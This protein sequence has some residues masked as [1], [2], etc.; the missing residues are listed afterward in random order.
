MIQ[1]QNCGAW[2]NV[3]DKFCATCGVRKTGVY[4]ESQGQVSRYQPPPKPREKSKLPIILSVVGAGVLVIVVVL[5][6]VLPGT[7]NDSGQSV[8]TSSV[9]G[10]RQ[11][12]SPDISLSEEPSESTSPTLSSEPS[13]SPSPAQSSDPSESPSPVQNS[14]PSESPSPT[15]SSEPPPSPSPAQN[16]EPPPSPS[17][18]QNSAPPTS[19]SPTQSSAPPTSPSPTQSSAPPTSPSVI[20][21]SDQYLGLWRCVESDG[22]QL[23]LLKEDGTFRSDLFREGVGISSSSGDYAISG[24][25]I[26]FSNIRVNGGYDQNATFDIELRGDVMEMFFWI[27]DRVPDSIAA[28]VL[29]DILAPYPPR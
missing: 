24:G 22:I 14:D 27:Y 8:S 15:Q 18:T 5:L 3:S 13:E 25:S 19:P 26:S 2:G 11:S 4:P 21:A 29:D 28:A 20:V 23:L 16:S 17:P 12:D 7:G 6:L 10:L 1:C 9:Q